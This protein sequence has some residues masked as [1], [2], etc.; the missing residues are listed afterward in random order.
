[1]KR[2]AAI[3]V[4]SNSVLLLIVEKKADGSCIEIL[5]KSRVTRL[6][7]GLRQ[8]GVLSPDSMQATAAALREYAE[9]LESFHVTEVAITGTM[10]LRTAGNAAQFVERIKRETGLVL[11]IIS[12][13]EEARLSFL[14][15]HKALTPNQPLVVF[16]VGGGSTE[17][18]F[19]NGAEVEQRFSLDVGAIRL[20]ED[21]LKSDPVKQAE[22]DSCFSAL[23]Q[24][25]AQL[26]F[27]RQLTRLIGIG[28]TLV[29][30][31]AVTA[32]MVVFDP[33]QLNNRPLR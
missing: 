7:R 15:A 26:S 16:D 25:F 5:E 9:I 14:A 19:G 4:G 24:E 13:E 32:E 20:T 31:A 33:N 2:Y 23:E 22:L 30:M 1:M 10:A 18:I 11:E 3:D 8:S 17:F 28:G 12:G 27:K 6:G 29:N 21:Y